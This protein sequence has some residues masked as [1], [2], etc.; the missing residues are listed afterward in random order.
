MAID[1]SLEKMEE[2]F[3]AKCVKH[4]CYPLLLFFYKSV[5]CSLEK[6]SVF[7][8]VARYRLE[9]NKNVYSLQLIFLGFYKYKSWLWPLAAHLKKKERKKEFFGKCVEDSDYSFLLSLYISVGCSLE[10]IIGPH[11]EL[12]SSILNK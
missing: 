4:R 1:R 8:L 2:K 5:R 12:P 9:I 6:L 7:T 11:R 3:F 10:K